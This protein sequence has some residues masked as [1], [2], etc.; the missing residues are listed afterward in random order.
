MTE[1]GQFDSKYMENN[2]NGVTNNKNKVIMFEEGI[3]KFDKDG[4]LCEVH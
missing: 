2:E 3:T 1:N 4:Q